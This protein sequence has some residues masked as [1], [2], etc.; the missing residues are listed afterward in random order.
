MNPQPPVTRMR[1]AARTSSAKQSAPAEYSPAIAGLRS[2][3]EQWRTQLAATDWVP[4]AIL[5]LAAVLRFFLLGIKPPHFDEGINGWFVDQVV[6]NGF[7]RSDPTNYHGPLHF[8]VLLFSESLLGRNVWALRLPVV[9]VSIGCVWLALKFEPLVGRNVSRIAALAMAVSP[10]FVF[11]GRYAIHEVWLQFF[12]T[13]FI[14]GLLGLWKL[15]RVNYLWYAGMGI[16]GMILTKETY[17]IHVACGVIAILFLMVSCA[18]G[19]V[20]DTRPA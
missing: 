15:G 10:A 5:G 11:F 19:R 7:Y 4:W 1:M 9:L 6:H 14:L 8:Y 20:P 2:R 12:S 16:A 17:A 13:M 18:L 3:V